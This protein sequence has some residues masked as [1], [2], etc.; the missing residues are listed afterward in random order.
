MTTNSE[1][2]PHYIRE[3]DERCNSTEAT[4]LLRVSSSE[5]DFLI[6]KHDTTDSYIHAAKNELK[7]MASSSS[8]TTL[9]L[10]LEYSFYTANV[11]AV[12]HLG[13]KE[14]GAMTLA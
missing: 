1:S 7:W 13:A 4:P 9:T 10:F 8:L 11:L 6:A 5:L 14:L 12:G 2:Q 3:I